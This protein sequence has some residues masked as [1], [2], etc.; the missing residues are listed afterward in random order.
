MTI[1]ILVAKPTMEPRAAQPEPEQSGRTDSADMSS[2][3]SLPPIDLL[4]PV[5]VFGGGVPAAQPPS[6]EPGAGLDPGEFEQ[7]L[8]QD[9]ER[10]QR[11]S[12]LALRTPEF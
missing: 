6:K 1:A 3:S 4:P 5:D 12:E 11:Y 10:Q 2:L 8:R 7:N 9:E